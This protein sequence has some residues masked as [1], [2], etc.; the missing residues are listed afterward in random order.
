MTINRLI[1]IIL[2]ILLIIS[3]LYIHVYAS[4]L[5][6]KI[7][8]LERLAQTLYKEV[9]LKDYE[10]SKLTI[11]EISKLVPSIQYKGKT[12]VEG[13]E[14][15]SATVIS[16]KRN[17]AAIKPNH[18]SIIISTTQLYLAIDALSH[19][20][21]PLW[22]RYYNVVEEDLVKIKKGILDNSSTQT[23]LGIQD[24]QF[25]YQLIRPAVQV[26]R[27]PFQVEKFDSLITALKSQTVN[28][29]KSII[30]KQLDEYV[31]Q[32]FHGN[33]QGTIGNIMG[34]RI[35]LRTSVGMGI[36]IFLALSYVIW[37]KFKGGYFSV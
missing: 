34:E 36:I 18:Q 32:L 29:N 7:N 33:D 31:H 8:A 9:K 6:E 26:S 24:L 15:I 37:R 19:Q 13:I 22:L 17:L 27:Q 3:S 4:N 28:Q 21:Q 10:K 14:A 1:K 12:T 25:H 20:A 30:L 11:E 2:F 35:L 23:D 16:T 5:D